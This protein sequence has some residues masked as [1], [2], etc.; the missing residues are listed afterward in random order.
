MKLKDLFQSTKTLGSSSLDDIASDVESQEYVE[1]YNKDKTRFLPN[2]DYSDPK[3]FAFFGSAEKYYTDAFVRIKNTFPYDG[4]EKE[5]YDWLNNSTLLDL[6]IYENRYPRFNGYANMGYPTWGTLSGSLIDGYGKASTNTYIKTFGGPHQS[7]KSGLKKQFE[8][9]NVYATASLKSTGSTPSGQFRESNLN[10]NLSGGVT[11]EMWLKKPAFDTSK[12]EKEV[13]FDLWNGEPSSSAQY[14]RLRLE[15][16]GAS[17]GSPFLLTA[18]SGTDGFQNHSIGDNLTTASI[19]DWTHVALSMKNVGVGN[20]LVTNF[21][22]N[23]QL[24]KQFKINN[25]AL[26]QVTGSLISYIGA[27]QTAPSGSP[28]IQAGAGKFSGSIDE[29]R[30]WKTERTSKEIGRY[31]WTNIGGGTN[32]DDANT[33]L[34]VYYK[35][36]E[37]ITQTASYDA[38]V[39]DYSGRVSNGAWTGYQSGARS[40]GSAIVLSSTAI[41]EYKDPTIYSNHPDYILI[42][43]ELEASGS[44][45]DIENNSSLFNSMPS[46]ILEEDDT[47]EGNLRNL[48]QAM[49]SYFDN[50][51]LFIKEIN[52]LKDIYA[53]FQTNIVDTDEIVGASTTSLTGAVK[54]LPFAD[55]LLTNAAFVAPELFA[56]ATVLEALADRSEDEHYEMKIHNVKNQIYQNVYSCLTKIYKE[57]GSMKAFRN[58]LHSFGI[59]EDVVK[60]NFYGDNVDFEIGDKH[61]IRARKEKFVDF[62][63]PDRF[64]GSIYQ[65]ASGT[66]GESFISGSQ[67]AGS[68]EKYIP[69]TFETQVILPNKI[70]W[71]EPYGFET[72]HTKSSIAGIHRANPADGTDFAIPSPDYCEIQLYSERDIKESKRVKF[73][74]SSS[75]LDVHLSSSLYHNQYLNNEWYLAFKLVNER[76][77]TPDAVLSSSVDSDYIIHFIGYNTEANTVLNSFHYSAS[78]TQTNAQNFLTHA[79]RIYAGAKRQNFTGGLV[80][81]ADHKI[82]YVRYWMSELSKDVMLN[83]ANDSTNYGAESPFKSAYLMETG[84]NNIKVPQIDTLMLHWDFENLST[85]DSSGEFIALDVTSGSGEERYEQSFERIKRKFYHGKGDFFLA[86][87]Q[88]VIDVEYINAARITSPEHMTGDDMI[89]IRTQDDLQFTRNTLPQDYFIA[90]EKSMSQTIS[91]E[92]INFMSSITAFNDLIGRPVDRYRLEYKDLSKLRQLFFERISNE[93]DLDKYIDYYKWLDDAL[94][95][96]LVALVPASIKHSDGVNNVIENHIFDRDKYEH[97]FPTIEFQTPEPEGCMKTINRHLYPWKTG[98]API[99][100]QEDDNCFWWLERAERDTVTDIVSPSDLPANSIYVA[101]NGDVM[102]NFSEAIS[103]IKLDL[104]GAHFAWYHTAGYALENWNVYWPS[105]YSSLAL[106]KGSSGA[107]IPAGSGILLKLTG[108]DAAPLGLLGDTNFKNATGTG[109]VAITYASPGTIAGTSA[110]NLHT[111]QKVFQARN[112]QL[113]R[114]WCTAQ[115]FAVDRQRH[116][117]GGT[118]YEDNKRRDYIWSATKEAAESPL[119]YG[120]FG[121]FPLRYVLVNNDMFT[122]LKD[123]SDERPVT[124]KIKRAFG[125]A[126]GFASFHHHFTGSEDGMRKGGMVVPFNIMSSSVDTGYSSQVNNIPGV[127]ENIDLTNLHSDTVDNTN[128]IPMQ[129]PFTETYVGG[130]QSR[131]APL[132]RGTD[133]TGSRGE[134]YRILINNIEN[135][136]GSIGIVAPDYPHPHSNTTDPPHM[137]VKQAKA[138]YFREERAKRPVNIRNIQTSG[139]QVGNYQKNYQFV[140]TFGR[141][142][143]KSILNDLAHDAQLHNATNAL[144]PQTTQEASLIARSTGSGGNV[145][146]NFNNSNLY[147]SDVNTNKAAYADHEASGS[148]DSIIVNRF[149][150]PGGFETMSEVFLDLYSKEKSS[151][152]ALPFRN[153]QI[154]GSGSGEPGSI[155]LVD[156]HGNRYGLLTHLTRHS[157]QFG[158]DSVIGGTSPSFH[159]VNRNPKW[160][161]SEQAYDY[162]NY[163]I[164]HQIPQSDFQYKWV[165]SS[166]T[167]SY[168]TSSLA[169]HVLSNYSEPS[170]TTSKYP[171]EFIENVVESQHGLNLNSASLPIG[172]VAPLSGTRDQ[173]LYGYPSWEQIR[174][175]DRNINVQAKKSYGYKFMDTNIMNNPDPSGTILEIDK[176]VDESRVTENI[177]NTVNI[178]YEGSMFQFQYPFVN[179]KYHFDNKILDGEYTPRSNETLYDTLYSFYANRRSDNMKVKAKN[180][181]QILFPQ[182]TKHTKFFVRHRHFFRSHFWTDGENEL[183][184][185]DINETGSYYRVDEIGRREVPVTA[186]LWAPENL[187]TSTLDLISDGLLTNIIPSQ[188]IWSMDGRTNFTSSD[189]HVAASNSAGAPGVLQ[190]QDHHFH[191]DLSYSQ[192]LQSGSAATGSF[193]AMGAT[194]FGTFASGSFTVHGMQPT[195][196]PASGSF[197][198]TGANVQGTSGSGSFTLAEPFEPAAS[199]SI[200]FTVGVKTSL[201]TT[202]TASFQVSGAHYPGSVTQTTL[203]FHSG[204]YADGQAA[205]SSFTLANLPVGGNNSYAI[206]DVNYNMATD[207]HQFILGRSSDTTGLEIRLGSS[208]ITSGFDEVKPVTYQKALAVANTEYASGSFDTAGQRFI[209]STWIN[210]NSDACDINKRKMIYAAYSGAKPVFELF[211]NSGSNNTEQRKLEARLYR[212][213]GAYN[214]WRTQYALGTSNF[215]IQSSGW[216]HLTC[217]ADESQEITFYADAGGQFG[218]ALSAVNVSSGSGGTWM[219]QAKQHFVMGFPDT[220]FS[221]G[222]QGSPRI[223]V[224]DMKMWTK[225]GITNSTKQGSWALQSYLYQ[226]KFEPSVLS[227]SDLNFHYRF[228]DI[229]GDSTQIRGA[230]NDA[231]G[232]N[233]LENAQDYD[234]SSFVDSVFAESMGTLEYFD[235]IVSAIEDDNSNSSYFDISYE[236]YEQTASSDYTASFWTGSGGF[237]PGKEYAVAS[238]D[239]MTYARFFVVAKQE[240]HASTYQLTPSVFSGTVLPADDQEKSFFNLSSDNGNTQTNS[241][242]GD[243]EHSSMTFDG[244]SIYINHH[245]NYQTSVDRIQTFTNTFKQGLQVS[246]TSDR[247]RLSGNYMND[248]FQGSSSKDFSI[249]YWYR[250][251]STFTAEN[252]LAMISST[253]G[254]DD[255]GVL[256]VYATDN[257]MYL[258]LCHSKQTGSTQNAYRFWRFTFDA[259]SKKTPNHYTWTIDRSKIFN[260]N[261]AVQLY[262][263]GVSQTIQTGSSGGPT[264]F[265]HTRWLGITLLGLP[266]TSNSETHGV[267]SQFAIWNKILSAAEI[268]EAYHDGRHKELGHHSAVAN[269]ANWYKLGDD[270]GLSNGSSLSGVTTVEDHT[271]RPT[272]ASDLTVISGSLIVVNMQVP[273]NTVSDSTFRSSLNAT[274]DSVITDYDADN[275]SGQF[276]LTNV[277]Q[278]GSAGNGDIM[279]EDTSLITSLVSPSEGGFDSNGLGVDDVVYIY[280]R[281]GADYSSFPGSY[282][283]ANYVRLKVAANTTTTSTP[284][285]GYTADYPQID[286]DDGSFPTDAD[287]YGKIADAINYNNALSMS[288]TVQNGN[289]ILIQSNHVGSGS[290]NN[291]FVYEG[292]TDVTRSPISGGDAISGSTVGHSITIDTDTFTLTGSTDAASQEIDITGVSNSDVWDTLEAQINASSSFTVTSTSS[293]GN[294]ATFNLE[295]NSAGSSQNNKFSVS[296]NSFNL[297]KDSEGGANESG[298]RENHYVRLYAKVNDSNEAYEVI[299]DKDHTYTNGQSYSASV[300]PSG[301]TKIY[302]DSTRATNGL[303]W[304]AIHDALE[305]E[306]FDVSYS[307]TATQ[308]TYVVTN[309]I[310]GTAGNGNFVAPYTG[311]GSTSGYTFSFVSSWSQPS[312]FSGG[313]EPRGAVAGQ[314]LAITGSDGT[315]KTFEIVHDAPSNTAT[316]FQ[317][318]GDSA[319]VDADT[320]WEN[321]RLA[322]S[323]NTEFTTVVT[324]SD[325][326]R[327]FQITSSLTGTA[328]NPSLQTIGTVPYASFGS[329]NSHDGTDGKGAEDGDSITIDGQTFEI[330][331]AAGLGTGSSSDF[332]NALS[333]SISS[334]TDFTDI[335]ITNLSNGF[336][337]FNL[338]SSVTGTAKNV[339]FTQNT[340]GGRTTFQNLAG[341]AG[342][343]SPIGIADLDRIQFS[344]TLD[345]NPSHIWVFFTV[346]DVG[347]RSDTNT[348]KYIDITGYTGTDSEK[349]T[350]FWN[351]LSAAIKQHTAFDTITINES[352]NVATFSI[353]SSVTG[354]AYNDDIIQVYDYNSDGVGFTIV[355][356]TAGGTDESGATAGHTLTISNSLG[357]TQF[358]IVHDSSPGARQINASGVTDQQFFDAI[359]ASIKEYSTYDLITWTSASNTGSFKLTASNGAVDP[360]MAGHANQYHLTGTAYNGS[361]PVGGGTFHSTLGPSGGVDGIHSVVNFLEIIPQPRYNYP[362]AIPSPGSLRCPTD[363]SNLGLINEAYRLRSDHFALTRSLGYHSDGMYDNTSRWVT[364]DLTGLTPFDEDYDHYYERIRGLNHHHALVP[365]FRISTHVK[366]IINSGSAEQEYFQGTGRFWLELTGTSLDHGAH[367]STNEDM[368]VYNP[369]NLPEFVGEFVS[370]SRIKYMDKF[371]EDNVDSLGVTGM[372][373]AALTLT[374]EAIKSFLPYEGFYPQTRTVQLCKSFAGSFAKSIQAAEADSSDTTLQFPDNNV[375][376]QARPIFDVMMSPGLLYNTIKSGIAVDYPV[377]ETKMA[378]ASIKDPY[379]GTNYMITNEFFEDRLP[380]ETLLDP[381]K[382]INKKWIVDLNPHPSSSFNLKAQIGTPSDHDYKLMANNFF[383]ESMAFFLDKKSTSRIVSLP[384]GDPLFGVVLARADG[385]LP[386][387]RSV[388]KVYKS[389]KEHPYLE[390]SSAVDIIALANNPSGV[391]D[392]LYNRPPS[393][394]NYFE[395]EYCGTTGTD[396]EYDIEEVNYPRPNM[397]PYAEVGTI[398]MYSQPNAFGPP[399]AGGVSVAFAGIDSDDITALTGDENNTTYMMYDSTNGYNAPFTPPYYDGEA[400]AIYTFTPDRPGKH[401]LDEIMQKTTV[402]FLR[403]EVN[404]ESGSYGDRGTFG[405]QGFTLN[406]NAMQV[407]ASFNLFKKAL[408]RG[409]DIVVPAGAVVRGGGTDNPSATGNV[410]VIE[411]KYETPIL[412]FAKYLN[413][414]YNAA[415]EASV[416]NSD[417]YTGKISLSGTRQEPDTLSAVDSNLASVHHLSG[418]LN[419]IGMWHQFGEHPEQSDVGIFMQITDL[420]DDYLE[421]GSEMTIPNPKYVAVA[422][423]NGSCDGTGLDSLYNN[424]ANARSSIRPYVSQ[425]VNRRRLVGNGQFSVEGGAI[426]VLNKENDVIIDTSLRYEELQ[427]IFDLTLENTGTAADNFKFFNVFRDT[428]HYTKEVLTTHADFTNASTV[429]NVVIENVASTDYNASSNSTFAGNWATSYYNI[430]RESSYAPLMIVTKD[431]KALSYDYGE[432]S[433]GPWE[434]LLKDFSIGVEYSRQSMRFEDAEEVECIPSAIAGR[435]AVFAPA[436]VAK[437]IDMQ[438]STLSAGSLSKINMAQGSLESVLATTRQAGGITSVPVTTLITPESKIVNAAIRS[439]KKVNTTFK[440]IKSSLKFRLIPPCPA[441]QTASPAP[442]LSCGAAVSTAGTST[443]SFPEPE[444]VRGAIRFN[445]GA[446]IIGSNLATQLARGN[447]KKYPQYAPQNDNNITS[448]ASTVR[449]GGFMP[450]QQ[451][452]TAGIKSLADLVGFDTEPVKMGV[453]ANKRVINEAIVAIPYLHPLAAFCKLD[454]YE[455]NKWLFQNGIIAEDRTEFP[456]HAAITQEQIDAREGEIELDPVIINQIEQMQRYVIPPH[457]DFV[458]YDVP[459]VPMYI[460]EYT[461]EL[462]RDDLIS[463]WQGVATENMKKVQFDTK[464]ITHLLTE[465]SFLGSLKQQSPNMSILKD[466]KWRVFKVKQR[467]ESNYDLKMAKDMIDLGYIPKISATDQFE[468]GNLGYNWPYDF[469]S[470]VENAQMKVDI[471]LVEKPLP[472]SAGAGQGGGSDEDSPYSGMQAELLDEPIAPLTPGDDAQLSG[473]TAEALQLDTTLGSTL[474]TTSAA[475][476]LVTVVQGEDS[477]VLSGTMIETERGLVPVEQ[478]TIEDKVLSYDFEQNKS[479]YYKILSVM[480]PRLRTKWAKV[481]TMSGRELRCTEEHPLY[482]LTA[483]NNE[484][485]VNK[486]SIGSAVHVYDGSEFLEDVVISVEYFNEDVMVYNFEVDEVHSYISDGVLSHNKQST[487][488]TA[489]NRIPGASSPGTIATPESVPIYNREE[490]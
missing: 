143:Q 96:M 185:T 197:E 475:D 433:Q 421:K 213:N 430:D 109:D 276:T 136:S 230:I 434:E 460:F 2:V 472:P 486:L 394:T 251:H 357:E 56:D 337:R 383:A 219:S 152:N 26:G 208:T 362:H 462:D 110:G 323:G 300:Q 229:N 221:W 324:G 134:G 283:S 332:H 299:P 444:F 399:C 348:T 264:T 361:M 315:A 60:I 335:T 437:F 97:K 321:F 99:P 112:S 265:V 456:E 412:N 262:I 156:I 318:R 211:F 377:V 319:S 431:M 191:N 296:G 464:S 458:R 39:L 284:A 373:P 427:T 47:K 36:N 370:T 289:E 352:N 111:R 52:S 356:D 320:F 6:Y 12:T 35:F 100:S 410:W 91:E 31:Y 77:P 366:D 44:I 117:H 121:G 122:A 485:P 101:A 255:Y 388:F 263:N 193:M 385:A 179:M 75:V 53:Q 175:N 61:N 192:L 172:M 293:V 420:P 103:R 467:A 334:S 142:I 40:T 490:D 113:R 19:A 207:G 18:M 123:C 481:K 468:T 301:L 313:L 132:N 488:G 474:G 259:N 423:D 477:C 17:S 146:S 160:D 269:L 435:D 275:T 188:S 202:A 162:D 25:G 442:A 418:I 389:K 342:G 147:L 27:L 282:G 23:G 135:V 305:A 76:Y 129:G 50:A 327:T 254:H 194:R 480:S 210:V 314:K 309:Y 245:A 286:V 386:I 64:N 447:F 89:E 344:D 241:T 354:T 429:L 87:D 8:D 270:L 369:A 239:T 298:A 392:R 92:M 209:L 422:P 271:Y 159:K 363:K 413:R 393:G 450:K 432:Y 174:N 368:P 234:N 145:A 304:L 120:E 302:V 10:Y 479:G 403:Y 249:S 51:Y 5:R 250:R 419:P 153:L 461:M 341:A 278:A 45:Y 183:Y 358:E 181:K 54:P 268:S 416:S 49:A 180:I 390:V 279:T 443:Y 359:T 446:A 57:K 165:K 4:S 260:D 108:M 438:N 471:T 233:D 30:Y 227:S 78:V 104:E 184:Q 470:I 312:A 267:L 72:R 258:A 189:H 372:V 478:I 281:K 277:S 436:A 131:H 225:T 317:I 339:A 408:K 94:G 141:F 41:K 74:L 340:N 326:P 375:L 322:I 244:E 224:S 291:G 95:E 59:D 345:T 82:G 476:A 409:S 248:E 398:T 196:I 79:K 7:S 235:S 170:G 288:A 231:N 37:G 84:A 29:F 38:T 484:M 451:N 33:D 307:T 115:H 379:G 290:H 216:I 20:S 395:S 73:H 150:A 483:F 426:Q 405:P 102:Y 364:P 353:T 387:Y 391:M 402:E 88:K 212:D 144:L 400:W 374:C 169:G 107:N 168:A 287:L 48:T 360:F 297:T 261:S 257:Y 205:T 206:F 232:S 463:I 155:R 253:N 247:P 173:T 3:N 148:G 16:T 406:E 457:L 187:K 473:R 453:T 243:I 171:H 200:S 295:A 466:I 128:A 459:P 347:T 266:S 178:E 166:H 199:S 138:R 32:K 198:I 215:P 274:I 292:E 316:N 242:A 311:N 350:Q 346:D 201:E 164:Q 114:S 126:D 325:T 46:W 195:G 449:W 65:Y 454:E 119:H 125:A 489:G 62:N 310:T 384:E 425:Q 9:A 428:T 367:V 240:N 331:L 482:S 70:P 378:T 256:R 351:D 237:I 343:T 411:S 186:T 157:A 63:H 127:G 336:Y 149:S 469:C 415:F 130:H 220:D 67:G 381:Q 118:N 294:I 177:P 252:T 455:V 93:P 86:N 440:A 272:T 333:S 139:S 151:Y 167:A 401:T 21:Y 190:N 24:N 330:D 452:R 58:V 439:T 69:V 34:G 15:L 329:L 14:G 349:S 396:L 308:A 1:S 43:D 154:K 407:D 222:T 217:F 55:R 182:Y 404:H 465:K 414:D 273:D 218:N 124:E 355:N 161:A 441:V 203:T 371:I 28:T 238:G 81:R 280:F 140:H 204:A 306:G 106:T 133:T 11:I 424:S 236:V 83:H 328:T 22:V 338:T 303:W 448:Q 98:H 163:W 487:P 445:A 71:E 214:G 158:I 80:D 382:H 68:F 90:F 285:S 417:I 223:H 137:Y 365:E 42:L 85:S 105:T 246:S 376:A 226:N 13:L 116:L 397:N 66:N 228:G 380:F 176:T